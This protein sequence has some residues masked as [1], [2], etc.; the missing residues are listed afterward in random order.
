M[1]AAAVWG[2]GGE[3]AASSC[4]WRRGL[5]PFFSLVRSP[6]QRATALDISHTSQY[7][8]GLARSEQQVYLLSCRS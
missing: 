1:K 7:V 3:L 5:V 6:K 8:Y 2:L 4:P